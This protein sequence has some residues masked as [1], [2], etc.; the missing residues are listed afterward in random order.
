MLTFTIYA[1]NKPVCKLLQHN[2]IDAVIFS[3]KQAPP[4]IPV[5]PK[6]DPVEDRAHRFRKQA[7][8][9]ITHLLQNSFPDFQMA[10]MAQTPQQVQEVIE[11]MVNLLSEPGVLDVPT[12]KICEI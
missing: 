2:K 9:R 5:E 1:K 6:R 12:V 7:A 3:V 10:W 8:L 4:V 11:Q